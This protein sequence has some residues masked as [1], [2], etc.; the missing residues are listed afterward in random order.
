MI[1]KSAVSLRAARSAAMTRLAIVPLSLYAGKNT[2]RP[3]F[4]WTGSVIGEP[5]I[6]SSGWSIRKRAA[7]GGLEAFRHPAPPE[8]RRDHRPGGRSEPRPQRRIAGQPEDRVRDR[9]RVA[10]RHHHPGA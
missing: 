1:S 10:L 5:G 3:G 7:V 4:R 8:T 9:A 6:L 2:L